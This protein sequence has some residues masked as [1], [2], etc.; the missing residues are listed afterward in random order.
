MCVQTGPTL[1]LMFAH[2]AADSSDKPLK[3]LR[4]KL[5]RWNAHE[6]IGQRS[7]SAFAL[8]RCAC[9]AARDAS[10]SNAY[11]PALPCGTAAQARL[12]FLAWLGAGGS[13]PISVARLCTA[14]QNCRSVFDP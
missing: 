10:N 7:V 14:R 4:P 1:P 3:M 11:N 5:A 9:A 8:V 12:G 13:H 6:A 2:R